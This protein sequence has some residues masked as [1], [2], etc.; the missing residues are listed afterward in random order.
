M[1]D[2]LD[3]LILTPDGDR[4]VDIVAREQ[5]QVHIETIAKLGS[6][7]EVTVQKVLILLVLDI[8]YELSMKDLLVDAD[9]VGEG[10]I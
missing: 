5:R 3:C 4:K 6:S 9:D 8:F 1:D 7:I 10:S 2:I